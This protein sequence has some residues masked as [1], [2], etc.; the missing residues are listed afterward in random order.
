M[1][2]QALALLYICTAVPGRRGSSCGCESAAVSAVACGVVVRV[3]RWVWMVVRFVCVIRYVCARVCPV[4]VPAPRRDHPRQPETFR[5]FVTHT[6]PHRGAFAVRT[7]AAELRDR[8]AFD[9][10]PIATL[11]GLLL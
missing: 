9:V 10:C 8:N 7:R 3:C 1:G 5:S 6:S 4:C 11:R 2:T